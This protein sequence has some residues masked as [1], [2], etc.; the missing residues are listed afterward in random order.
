MSQEL[1]DEYIDQPAFKAQTDFAVNEVNRLLAA[2]D[3]LKNA[4]VNIAGAK[5]LSDISAAVKNADKE[6]KNLDASQ[7]KLE[8]SAKRAAAEQQRQ[9]KII[10]DASN[11]FKQL[12]KAVADAELKYKNY[13]LALGKA[14]PAT[15]QAKKDML[16]LKKV[17]VGLNQD[18]GNFRDNVGNYQNAF[19]KFGN[20]LTQ[21]QGPAKLLG[22]AIGVGGEQLDQIRI[23][24]EHIAST[25]GSFI[26]VKKKKAEAEII[27]AAATNVNTTAM[28][29]Q[30]TTYVVTTAATDTLVVSNEALAVSEV[31]VA[32]AT[33]VASTSMKAF[34][35]ALAATG[36][37]VIIAGLA[38]VAYQM[39]QVS[40]ATADARRQRELLNDVNKQAAEGAGKE[41]ATLQTLYKVATNANIPIRERYKAVDEIQ[42]QYPE[43]FK[44]IKDEIILQ[45]KAADAYKATTDA[46]LATAK[47]RAIENK[48]SELATEE[49]QIQ[50]DNQEAILDLKEAKEKARVNE[51]KKRAQEEKGYGNGLTVDEKIA[52][53]VT[54]DA[55]TQ[56]L[57]DSNK[58]LER[59]GK[60]REFLLNQITTS[61]TKTGGGDTASK[62]LKA[63]SDRLSQSFERF[64]LE[65]NNLLELLKEGAD[66]ENSV[67]KNRLK[68]LIQFNVERKVLIEEQLKYDLAKIE[69]KRSNDVKNLEAEKKKK[70]ADVAGINREIATINFNASEAEK[71]AKL[72]ADID[73]QNA[74]RENYKARLKLREEYNKVQQDFADQEYEYERQ[75]AEKIAKLNDKRRE[76]MKKFNKEDDAALEEKKK[77]M[78][79]FLDIVQNYYNQV[80]GIISS[81]FNIGTTKKKNEAQEAI[82]AIEKQK[83]ADLKA[84]DARVQSEQDKAAN[85]AIINSRA[86]QQKQIQIQRQK[87]ADRRQAQA[88][89]ALS[90]FNITL[91]IAKAV[92]S[93]LGKPYL[94]ALD[95]ALGGAQL[96]I[97]AATP[98]PRFFRGKKKGVPVGAGLGMVNDHPDGVTNEII[99][100]ADGS[101]T[102]PE[103]RN[104]VMPLKSSDIVHPS[105]DEFIN[106]AL[107]AAH[108]DT[109]KRMQPAGQKDDKVYSALMYQTKILK[110]MAN[111]PVHNTILT[112][113]GLVKSTQY[114]NNEIKYIHEN[115][116]W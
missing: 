89:K 102:V 90:I 37:A 8:A 105:V 95:L 40:K 86:E 73:L 83:D 17:M 55:L 97:A 53:Q 13:A 12:T 9:A 93:H 11:D 60:D 76:E 38:Y 109:N 66:D 92:A 104:V 113:E 29:A 65:Q 1:I 63:I 72:K 59:I 85:I 101:L 91:S 58:R 96:A 28:Q 108:R 26:G 79:S 78:L 7:R 19:T 112:K 35:I 42:K 84:N 16:E 34:R 111:R 94:I 15:I 46:I 33:N 48:L 110:V 23:A 45:G 24:V 62:S 88:D 6:I 74:D 69:E 4:K 14:S 50:F 22:E 98:I 32:A 2:F 75:L 61:G 30:A 47:T 64:K 49:L 56:R 57:E 43:H 77:K 70:G 51:R 52:G 5:G 82:D 18:T 80:S 67:Y 103:G 25:I 68:Y 10:D 99:E 41:I 44:N 87:E 116:N 114:G 39:Y 20:S 71:T 81:A 27:D 3:N 107:G 106:A 36:I 54:V 115:T 31:E 21:F 100:H